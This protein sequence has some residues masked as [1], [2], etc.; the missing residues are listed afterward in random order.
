M[1]EGNEGVQGSS[2]I[3]GEGSGGAEPLAG[4]QGG[5]GGGTPTE[6][7]D[8]SGF[9]YKYKGRDFTPRDRNHLMELV[10]Q[11][12]GFNSEIDNIK[13]QKAELEEMKQKYGRY[14]TLHSAFESN[15]AF[16]QRIWDLQR[17]YQSGEISGE[18]A[19]S[20]VLEL[21][22]ELQ[23]LKDELK[24]IHDKNADQDIQ[25]EIGSLR[26]K[27]K[28]HDWD[29]EQD[30]TPPLYKRIIKHA[31]DNKIPSLEMAYR[32]YMWDSRQTTAK[33]DALKQQEAERLKNL[34]DGKVVAGGAKPVPKGKVGYEKGDEYGDLVS[35]GVQML[36]G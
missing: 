21:R 32:D 14:D 36:G 10:S 29:T 3:G 26:E 23:G 2:L 30:G 20:E 9:A 8:P 4:G 19:N 22:Q 7:F 24:Q 25:K 18:E 15:P 16:A 11:G 13:Q 31:L 27:Y 17:Q 5:Q 1:L 33:A 34:K 12:H 6:D 35:K 28:D